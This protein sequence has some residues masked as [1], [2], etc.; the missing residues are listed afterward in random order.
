MVVRAKTT[1][2]T[3]FDGALELL[4]QGGISNV[5]INQLSKQVGVAKT[6][7]YL[8]F[9]SREDLLHAMLKYW[10]D[11]FTQ[12]LTENLELTTGDPTKGLRKVAHLVQELELIKYDVA[13]ISWAQ[14]DKEVAEIVKD[15]YAQ[16]LS[17]INTMFCNLGYNDEL[18]YV[19]AQLFVS[20][21][22]WR[23][24]MM[25][26]DNDEQLNQRQRCLDVLL[27]KATA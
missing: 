13:I 24:F 21:F 23:P 14:Y 7:F 9:D 18:A 12:V 22:S 6:S 27:T 19:R 5:T 3:W 4:Q 25:F 8:H 16:R 11:T 1:R 26:D 17:L 20:Y 10:V 15:A 2:K